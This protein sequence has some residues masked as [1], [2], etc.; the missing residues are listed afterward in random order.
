[1]TGPAVS[2]DSPAVEIGRAAAIQAP[3]TPDA[4]G[5][6]STVEISAIVPVYRS[7]QIL[8]E[9][10]R[11]LGAALRASP[12]ATR[13]SRGRGG[14]DGSWAA[15][16]RLAEQDP[17]V[18]G[19]RMSRNYGQHNALL[20][21]IRAARHEITVTLDDDLQNP[22][23]EIAKLI[24]RLVVDDVD[25]VYG[26]PISEQHGFL[27]DRGSQIT[28][29]AL[30]SA[31]GAETARKVS[32]FRAFRTRLRDAFA[33]YGGPYV[34][35]DVLL[36]WGTTRFSHVSVRTR[37]R[38]RSGQSNYTFRTFVTHAFNMMTGFSTVPLQ[39]ASIIGFAVHV[40]RLR[41]PGDRAR[42]PT[43]PMAA[44]PFRASRSSPRSSRSSAA[45]SCSPWAS[46]AS[47]WPGCI[48]ARWIGPT[49]LVRRGRP[50]TTESLPT[51]LS[52]MPETLIEHGGAVIE[53]SLVPW[54]SEVF[55]FPVAQIGRI[56]LAGGSGTQDVLRQFDA[57]CGERDV[58]LVSCRLDH[59][60]LR[61]SM[62]LE[63]IGFRFVE[64][65]YVPRLD[66]AG[67]D[68]RAA[69][70]D[71]RRRGRA[72]RP[73][74]D[75]GDRLRGV[76]DRA[77]PAGLAPPRGAQQAALREVGADQLRDAAA[78]GAQGGGRR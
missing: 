48:S 75:R 15:I 33:A 29:L 78:D 58:R 27:R 18:R 50:R 44:V 34:S 17:H 61:E 37:S 47:T 52:T 28:K 3:R 71:R 14:G 42:S 38:A 65:V 60:R 43:S 2:G 57:W 6:T 9:L 76:H 23:E 31:M 13:S 12:R 59:A 55:G 5:A 20:C 39:I 25:V 19:I 35:I 4:A 26:T 32:A 1:M 68:P 51:I 21:G 22:P 74:R 49:Y 69:A 54:D 63:D 56:D 62:A 70:L 46:S 45:R 73:G 11:R 64:M 10:H 41:D 24:D 53:C 66:G 7:A 16:E 36:T 77:L 30:Q 67:I 40:V 8:P 72:W